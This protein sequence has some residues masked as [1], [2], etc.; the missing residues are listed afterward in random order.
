MTL[1]LEDVIENGLYEL[2]GGYGWCKHG[3]IKVIRGSDGEL[4]GYDTYWTSPYDNKAYLIRDVLDRLTFKLDLNNAKEV[5]EDEFYLYDEK[6][7]CYIP[8]GGWRERYLVRA[9]AEK[10]IDYIVYNLKTK[11][12]ECEYY[13]QYNQNKLERYKEELRKYQNKL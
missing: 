12:K 3:L 10:R 5:D 1:K 11:I 8:V 13:I 2:Q 9:N 7:R 4:Y 6:D